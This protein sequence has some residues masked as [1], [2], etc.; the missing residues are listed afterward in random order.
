MGIEIDRRRAGQQN[1]STQST[2]IFRSRA[3]LGVG[4][5]WHE[6]VNKT[7]FFRTSSLLLTRVYSL[8]QFPL[9]YF[10]TRS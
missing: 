4:I 7:N 1:P 2:R 8:H 5:E 10:P 6:E 3:V 9:F